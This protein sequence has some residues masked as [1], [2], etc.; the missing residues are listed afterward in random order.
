METRSTWPKLTLALTFHYDLSHSL[1]L[2]GK[3]HSDELFLESYTVI[4][5]QIKDWV[6]KWTRKR[7]SWA[8]R[9]G[10][11]SQ[12]ILKQNREKLQGELISLQMWLFSFQNSLILGKIW[13]YG[14]YGCFLLLFLVYF[15]Y[16][17]W[18]W[19]TFNIGHWR[20]PGKSPFDY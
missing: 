14:E 11:G 19:V 10:S 3:W 9:L 13:A 5:T 8:D 15:Y 2:S 17:D 4:M 16:R 1:K 20:I 6:T 18:I 7:M 12:Y